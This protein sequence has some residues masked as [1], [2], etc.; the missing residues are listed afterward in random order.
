MPK[1]SP[2]F[3]SVGDLTEFARKVEQLLIDEFCKG[4]TDKPGIAI[5]FTLPPDYSI[6]HYV[7]NLTRA[8]GIKLFMATAEKMISQT[9]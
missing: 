2:A 9:N 7:T 6:S 8:D 1:N 3:S 5:A 4:S